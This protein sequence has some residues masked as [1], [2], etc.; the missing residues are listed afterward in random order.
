MHPKR[1]ETS[2]EDIELFLGLFKDYEPNSTVVITG[3]EPTMID[4]VK[5]RKI[6]ALIHISGKKVGMLT[7]GYKLHPLTWFDFVNLDNH[8][9]NAK[10][11]VKWRIALK[12]SGRWYEE[13]DKTYHQDMRYAMKNNITQGFRCN[14][15]MQPL[16]L[17][18]DV[19]Y[20]CCN[21]MCVEWWIDNYDVTNA[22]RKA[23]WTIHNPEI[24]YTVTNWRK[25]LPSEFYRLC[26]IK[27]WK[28]ANKAKWRLIT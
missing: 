28:H 26:I 23:E 15:L 20:P 1:D 18:K 8:G 11:L 21:A 17:W 25:T 27:C 22:L 16:T 14:S 19:I 5:L 10:D 9:V 2:I 6:C 12:E 3:G 13:T 24:V 7:N 4:T